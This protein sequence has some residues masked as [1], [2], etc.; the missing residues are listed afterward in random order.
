MQRLPEELSSHAREEI[1]SPVAD[2]INAN[3]SVR[4]KLLI[5]ISRF[6]AADLPAQLSTNTN[7]TGPRA[8]VYLVAVPALCA[9]R[10]FL[11]SLVMP[12]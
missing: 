6:N 12:V 7:S 1:Y 5:S 2:S 4:N 9:A 8:R 10:R 3:F 11:R